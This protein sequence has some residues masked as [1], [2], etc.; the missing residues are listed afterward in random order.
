MGSKTTMKNISDAVVQMKV[1]LE[2]MRE[3]GLNIE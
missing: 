3:Q 1:Q 2:K